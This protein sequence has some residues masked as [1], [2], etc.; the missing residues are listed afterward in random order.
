[1]SDS[2]NYF[3]VAGRIVFK[4]PD[5]DAPLVLDLNAVATNE[6]ANIPSK[7]IAKMQQGLQIRFF[8]QLQNPSLQI[9]DVVIL[10]I[11]SLGVMTK[12]EFHAAPPGTKKQEMAQFMEPSDKIH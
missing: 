6:S 1:M 5:N 4:E 8:E 7:L 2:R 9:L 11:C 12:E 10:N 3:L